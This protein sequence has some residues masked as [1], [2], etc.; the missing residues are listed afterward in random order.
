V[1]DKLRHYHDHPGFVRPFVDATRAALDRLGDPAAR[2]VFT[3]HSVPLAMERSS[4]YAQQLRVTAGLVAGA[5]GHGTW[6]LVWQSRSGPPSVPW[7]EP[8]VNDHLR[9][10]Y[11]AGTRG[12][13]LVPIGFV[14]DHMEVVYDLD[15]EAVATA[16]Q[17]PGLRLERAGTPG[18]APDPRFVAMVGELVRERVE[19]WP[20]DRRPS[21]WTERGPSHDVCP[22]GCCPAPAAR[23]PVAAR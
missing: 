4:A 16:A 10:L 1:V 18:T 15:T 20:R 22:V 9:Q 6:D 19:G 7:L 8:D 13:V 11:D 5:L 23:R 2:L 17:L 3:A 12:V 14:S 21:L